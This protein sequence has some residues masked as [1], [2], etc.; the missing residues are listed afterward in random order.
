M[1][2]PYRVSNRSNDQGAYLDE[3]LLNRQTLTEKLSV[4]TE[5][6]LL[7]LVCV[8]PGVLMLAY[9]GIDTLRNGK[10]GAHLTFALS[11]GIAFVMLGCL[12]R[13][14]WRGFAG[15][16][17]FGLI[18]QAASLQMIDAGRL[19][20]F[21]NYRPVADLLSREVLFVAIVAIQAIAVMI[22][23]GQRRTDLIKCIRGIGTWRFLVL[24]MML[25]ISSAAVTPDAAKYITSVSLGTVVQLIALGNVF[26][27]VLCIPAT[28]LDWL[29]AKFARVFGVDSQTNHRKIDAFVLSAALAVTVV[30]GFLSYFVYQSHPHVPDETQY[31]FQAKYMAAGQLTVTPPRVPEA[32]SM[33]MVPYLDAR[34]YGIFPPA[35]PAVLAVGVEL[36]ALWIVNP[37]FAGICIVLGFLLIQELYSTWVARLSVILLSTSPWFVF[38]GMNLMSHMFTLACSLA[39]ALCLMYAHRRRNIWLA[40]SS[41]LF[42]GVV[43]LIRP[44]DGL[45]VGALLSLWATFSVTG[46]GDRV[47]YLAALFFG[48]LASAS[49]V[50]PY[51]KAVTGD[52]FAL[53]LE[54]YYAKYFWPGASSIGFGPHRGMGWQLDALPG[55]TP[56]EALINTALN[57]YQ[58]NAELLGW[59]TGSLIFIGYL[60]VS[61]GIRRKDLWAWITFL[62]IVITLGAFWYHGGPDFGPRYWFVAIVPL[63]ALTIRG[64]THLSER[65][66]GEDQ[67]PSSIDPRVLAAALLLCFASAVSYIPWRAADKYYQYLEMKPGIAE[68]ATRSGFGNGLVLVRGNE[69]PDYQSAWIFNQPNFDGPGPLYA[70]DK[71]PEIRRQLLE[72]YPDRQVWLVDGPT[73]TGGEYVLRAGPL[74]AKSLLEE[75]REELR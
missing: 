51:N 32:F 53:P 59:S 69:H 55:H 40:L 64:M 31:V 12:V 60:V 2:L 66:Q 72:A 26:L 36:G 67:T 4:R 43:S 35:F 47:R 73:L 71:S 54:T 20:H 70:A 24:M 62:L 16:A 17:A 49:L 44:L 18:G 28:S 22:G 7:P 1:W 29:N 15:W 13:T 10:F 46:W 42:V 14:A 37:I 11:A 68:L 65:M 25:G 56:F 34:W 63:V 50:L 33:Y 6:F 3:L 27:A 74:S 19:I 23:L 58:L 48:T 9:V 30:C 8:A 61:G 39:A 52:W 41:G 5:K 45:I 38:M 75:H 57:T 21:Q